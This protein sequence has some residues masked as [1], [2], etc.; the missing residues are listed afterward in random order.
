MGYL[1]R[2]GLLRER[3]ALINKNPVESNEFRYFTAALK[4]DGKKS[5]MLIGIIGFPG[6]SHNDGVQ[7]NACWDH[8]L[9]FGNHR[10]SA[11]WNDF[12]FTSVT[13][14]AAEN[15]LGDTLPID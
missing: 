3:F 1:A 10:N 14:D 15:N 7:K 11:D 2:S 13:E 5:G 8:R 4:H 12:S 6:F 9:S